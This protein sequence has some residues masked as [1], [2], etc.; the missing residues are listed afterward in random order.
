MPHSICNDVNISLSLSLT[1]S[2]FCVCVYI[3]VML[4]IAIVTQFSIHTKYIISNPWA[5]LSL[6]RWK[7]QEQFV[8]EWQ[9]KNVQQKWKIW[10]LKYYSSGYVFRN[11]IKTN[12]IFFLLF[13]SNHFLR[14]QK[15]TTTNLLWVD[16]H[17]V[18]FIFISVL[19]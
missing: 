9:K 7:E 6:L 18:L 19:N 12:A 8:N 15:T 1:R 16:R 10:G 14:S 4:T 17:Q 2:C 5:K 13:S 11:I 3:L